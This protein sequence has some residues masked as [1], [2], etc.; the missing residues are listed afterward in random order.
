MT[1]EMDTNCGA[2]AAEMECVIPSPDS[3][4]MEQPRK[5]VQ[6]FSRFGEPLFFFNR[7]L[8]RTWYF[9]TKYLV[10]WSTLYRTHQHFGQPLSG[11]RHVAVLILLVLRTA[12]SQQA[13]SC[14]LVSSPAPSSSLSLAFGMYAITSSSHQDTSRHRRVVHS[15]L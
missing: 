5:E 8:L 13:S 15:V 12:G 1:P 6:R 11:H 2:Y 7:T 9:K 4:G 10:V 14:E 3:A